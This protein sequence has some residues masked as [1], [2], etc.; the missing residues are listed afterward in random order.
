M[1]I[2][3]RKYWYIISLIIIVPGIIS[4]FTRGLNLGIDFTG[5]SLYSIRTEASVTVAQV[6]ASVDKMGLD[7][8]P[9]IQKA[10]NNEFLIR[11]VELNQKQSDKLVSN[12]KQDLGSMELLRAEK[13]GPVIGSELRTK[14]LLSLLVACIMMLIYI[15]IRFEFKY[16]VAA[17]ASLLHD[18]LFVIGV[19]S[20]FQWEVDSSFIAAILTILGYSINDTIVIF[21]RIRENQRVLMRKEKNLAVLADTSIWQTLTRSINTV[22]TVVFVLI[23]LLV[24]GGATLKFF[25]MALLI[26]FSVGCYSSIF[27]ASPIWYDLNRLAASK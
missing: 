12:L 13:V 25:V 21:D 24:F 10:G 16:G 27:V 20:I 18:A 19:F 11:T 14:A 5:G 8:E 23:G 15:S 17:I 26:G 6:R 3:K 1:F 2:E 22:L 7:K 4:L 9:T